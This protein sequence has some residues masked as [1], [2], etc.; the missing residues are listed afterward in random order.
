M[1][2]AYQHGTWVRAGFVLML[3]LIPYQG[4]IQPSFPCTEILMQQV[5][6]P[7]FKNETPDFDFIHALS[8]KKVCMTLAMVGW[9]VLLNL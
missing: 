3:A 7:F 1:W 2:S 5:H 8:K 6:I 4:A 9:F